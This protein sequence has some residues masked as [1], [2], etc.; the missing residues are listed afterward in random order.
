MAQDFGGIVQRQLGI[1]FPVCLNLVG[2]VQFEC[3]RQYI[4]KR[5]VAAAVFACLTG[6]LESLPK[7]VECF[8]AP[9]GVVVLFGQRLVHA[10]PSEMDLR[11]LE[12]VGI[13]NFLCNL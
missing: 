6:Q 2:L 1:L 5:H 13:G 8:L 4:G 10:A 3:H 7:V 12:S 9:F 11:H